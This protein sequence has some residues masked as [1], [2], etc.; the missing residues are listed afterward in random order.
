MAKYRIRPSEKSELA[1]SRPA[2]LLP[3]IT[4]CPSRPGVIRSSAMKPMTR[5]TRPTPVYART[6]RTDSNTGDSPQRSDDRGGAEGMFRLLIG[7]D[8][9]NEPRQVVGHEPVGLAD[10]E[11]RGL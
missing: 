10:P 7:N 3:S 1:A 5:I 11:A 4:R 8:M 2:P 9:R 6:C